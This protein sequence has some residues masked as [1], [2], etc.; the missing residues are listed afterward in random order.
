MFVIVVMNAKMTRSG[1]REQP[2]MRR[3]GKSWER[4]KVGSPKDIS[5][6]KFT[7]GFVGALIDA[8]EPI[9]LRTRTSTRRLAVAS[10]RMIPVCTDLT[11]RPQ[12]S[13]KRPSHHVFHAWSTSVG[14]STVDQVIPSPPH[15]HQSDPARADILEPHLRPGVHLTFQLIRTS[16]LC[17]QQP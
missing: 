5:P 16:D 4:E 10:R 9:A 7:P 13:L 17:E 1:K 8:R 12:T 2:T 3:V 6:L 14:R 11:L 15:Y